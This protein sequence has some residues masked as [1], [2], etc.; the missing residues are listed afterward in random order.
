M[1]RRI[2]VY[3]SAMT[4]TPARADVAILVPLSEE[5]EYIKDVFAVR[6]AFRRDTDYYF[7]L[8]IPS[9]SYTVVAHVVGDPG[10]DHAAIAAERLIERFRP[11]IMILIG[12]AGSLDDA[13]LLGDVVIATDIFAYLHSAKA[14]AGADGSTFKLEVAGE[15]WKA[16]YETLQITSNLAHIPAVSQR[17]EDWR[18]RAANRRGDLLGPV[19]DSLVRPEPAIVHGPIASGDIVGATGAF[20]RWLRGH[21]RK[22]IAIEME[23]GGA[24]VASASRSTTV[25]LLVVRGVSDFSD[26]RKGS[27]DAMQMDGGETGA[28]RRYA[29]ENAASL[30][31]LLLTLDDFL[32]AHPSSGPGIQQAPKPTSPPP[33]GGIESAPNVQSFVG[34]EHRKALKWLAS[35]WLEE[36]PPICLV[37]GFSG[38]GKTR[39]AEELTQKLPR[40]MDR[41]WVD[42]PSGEL[43]EVLLD[44][45]G[46]FARLGRGTAVL[47]GDL[48]SAIARSFAEP[49]LLI[50]DEFQRLLSAERSQEDHAS[51]ARF[52]QQVSRIGGNGRILCLSSISYPELLGRYPLQTLEALG[53]HEGGDLLE[54]LLNARGIPDAVSQDRQAD[55]V[56]WLGGNPRALQ[57]LAACLVCDPLDELV[58]LAPEAW[59]LRDRPVDPNLLHRLELGFLQRL[60]DRLSPISVELLRAISVYRQPFLREAFAS[61]AMPAEAL[62]HAR[63]ELAEAFI[64]ESRQRWYTLNPI[65]RE[66]ALAQI[67][68]ERSALVAAHQQASKYYTRHF[69]AK[70]VNVERNGRNFIEASYHLIRGQQDNELREIAVHYRLHLERAYSRAALPVEADALNERIAVLEA[71]SAVAVLSGQLHYHLARLLLARDAPEDRDRA[72]EHCAEAINGPEPLPPDRCVEAW[73]LYLRLLAPDGEHQ[74]LL[75]TLKDGLGQ[76]ERGRDIAR[77]YNVCI[78]LLLEAGE[79]SLATTLAQEAIECVEPSAGLLGAYEIATQL[80]ARMGN[81]DAAIDL[82]EEAI[83]RLDPET[84]LASAYQMAS[85]LHVRAGDLQRAIAIAEE[86][87]AH[88]D[89]THGL[90]GAYTTAVQLLARAGAEE[91]ALQLAGSAMAAL[92]PDAVPSQLRALHLGLLERCGNLASAIT[93]ARAGLKDAQAEDLVD[94]HVRIVRLLLLQGAVDEAVEATRAARRDLRSEPAARAYSKMILTLAD[95][96]EFDRALA[97]ARE[98]LE[99]HLPEDHAGSVNEDHAGSVNVLPEN[100]NILI[101]QT[102]MSLLAR[103]GSFADALAL[104]RQTIERAGPGADLS[105][106][107][108]TMF[109]H[110]EL[111]GQVEE[112]IALGYEAVERLDGAP[113]ASFLYHDTMRLCAGRGELDRA[114]ALGHAGI[115]KFFERPERDDYEL[116]ILY[117]DTIMLL[118]ANEDVDASILLGREGIAALRLDGPAVHVYQAMAQT[119]Q[120]AYGVDRAIA[121]LVEGAQQITGHVGLRLIFNALYVAAAAG[122]LTRLDSIEAVVTDPVQLRRVAALGRVL[123]LQLASAWVEGAETAARARHAGDSSVQLL[124]QEIFCLTCSNRLDDAR[125]LA[126]ELTSPTKQTYRLTCWLNALIEWRSGNIE[127]SHRY[128]AEYLRRELT[129][130]EKADR[131]L[132]LAIWEASQNQTGLRPAFYFPRNPRTL[133]EEYV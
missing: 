65:A 129:A 112:A 41:C 12:L 7:E 119:A 130:P 132:V 21:N 38:I 89:I 93:L 106:I 22:L 107:Y 127:A 14:V 66:L 123:R 70:R 56:A 116:S 13:V 124:T 26:E 54:A 98:G 69:H 100:G 120:R 97:L 126:Q 74:A 73:S 63:R 96:G 75:S 113:G 3:A 8:D 19:A 15:G 125:A 18:S 9:S 51:V 5:F 133:I 61:L 34:T 32:T 81:L 55:V 115:T 77:L 47:G 42:V 48:A 23:A 76:L 30:V 99:R 108:H 27:F 17:L 92:A 131:N 10:L 85:Q 114:I 104:G 59:E 102:A 105:S 57:V 35:T 68:G 64:L 2:N 101:Y 39:L 122:D 53:S 78:Q 94:T 46:E 111:S 60:F 40:S 16:P 71:A 79:I 33:G 1:K 121:C 44:I 24:G 87:I 86:A 110:L 25:P 28:W 4:G 72:R 90:A 50:L 58:G 31:G 91:R 82:S 118:G 62:D 128:L 11:Q 37:Q 36:G 84:G 20:T 49:I 95:A 67:S 88:L 6:S 109:D 103:N 45:T 80:L 43:E 117:H 83:E 52:L 29:V